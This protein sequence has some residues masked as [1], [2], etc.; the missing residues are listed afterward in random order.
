MGFT[1]EASNCDTVRIEVRYPKMSACKA[2]AV[3]GMLS[4]SFRDVKITSDE[5]GEVMRSAYFSDE[6][7]SKA[8]PEDECL[9]IV[10]EYLNSY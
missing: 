9:R 3:F 5:T 2:N 4:A 1:V 10:R 6:F 8:I 7:F